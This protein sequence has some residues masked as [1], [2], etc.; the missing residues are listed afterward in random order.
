MERDEK[1]GQC[2][3]GQLRIG[4]GVERESAHNR[5]TIDTHK[6]DEECS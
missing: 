2:A 3:G 5:H 1:R 6:T 4:H